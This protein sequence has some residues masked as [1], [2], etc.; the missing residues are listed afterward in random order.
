MLIKC[1]IYG[2]C[3]SSA[4]MPIT[5]PL[6]SPAR[7]YDMCGV[8]SQQF[9]KTA[10]LYITTAVNITKY[11]RTVQTKHE[12]TVRNNPVYITRPSFRKF[13]KRG[14]EI[15]IINKEATVNNDH[16]CVNIYCL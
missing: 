12:G 7:N 14:R 4:C 8:T 5:L 3:S 15:I 1:I 9:L 10:I 13:F 11:T 6:R 2:K 16:L